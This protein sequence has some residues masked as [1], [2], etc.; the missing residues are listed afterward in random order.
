HA[1]MKTGSMTKY[2]KKSARLTISILGGD[3]WSPIPCR[4]M[5]KT[6][7]IKGKQ[8]IM[9]ANPGARL[10]T[11][12]SARSCRVRADREPSS[13]RDSEIPCAIAGSPISNIMMAQIA[14]PRIMRDRLVDWPPLSGAR[15]AVLSDRRP[16]PQAHRAQS[17][18][19][20]YRAR[21]DHPHACRVTERHP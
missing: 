14:A 17:G 3:C 15:P 2:V 18:D 12:I 9:I 10:R 11:V 20:R 8:V 5:P 1:V 21:P 13:P 4:R 16:F 7:T 19:L 6:V